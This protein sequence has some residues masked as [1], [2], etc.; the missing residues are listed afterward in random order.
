M[1][2]RGDRIATVLRVRRAQEAEAAGGLARAGAA[3]REAERV[4]GA[5][6]DHYEQHRALDL[7]D[8][9]V[10][11]RLRDR[12]VRMLQAAAIQRGRARV[13]DALASMDHERRLLQVRSQAVRAS[14]NFRSGR[15]ARPRAK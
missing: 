8:D 4:L 10:D 13:R 14:V 5:L 12:Q 9:A 1:T 6:M 11:E 2:A 7:Q 15:K 3:A